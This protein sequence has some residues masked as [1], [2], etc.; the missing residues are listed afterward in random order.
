[1]EKCTGRAGFSYSFRRKV[2]TAVEN[3]KRFVRY[4]NFVW[5]V[6]SL[7]GLALL[8]GAPSH[9]QDETRAGLRLTMATD[10]FRAS[11]SMVVAGRYGGSWGA[12]LGFWVRDGHVDPGAPNKLAGVDHMWTRS[13]WRYGIGLVWIDEVNNVNGTRWN[14]DLSLAYDL[15]PRVFA[16][17]RHYSHGSNIGIRTDLPNSSWNFVGFGLTL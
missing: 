4:R 9:A 12:R 17:Y 13:N 8:A 6:A 2:E 14:L 1:M 15:S 16:E 10:V 7:A 5:V 11:G 3:G